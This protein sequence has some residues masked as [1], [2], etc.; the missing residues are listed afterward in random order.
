MQVFD[1]IY[2]TTAGGPEFKTES[3]VEYIY[4]RGFAAPYELGY[5]SS[6]ATIL[7]IIIAALAIASNLYM[8]HKEKQMR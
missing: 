8:S 6:V 2:V 7:F 5:A 3:A 4:S 1:Q